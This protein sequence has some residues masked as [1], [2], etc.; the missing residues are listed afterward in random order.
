[1]TRKPKHLRSA[2]DAQIRDAARAKLK[3]EGLTNYRV[4]DH[5]RVRREIR[6]AFAAA[7]VELQPSL[8][9]EF[10]V[11]DADLIS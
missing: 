10:F 9:G 6:G 8:P 2:T 3:R 7:A 5:A 4:F 11:Y 1:M